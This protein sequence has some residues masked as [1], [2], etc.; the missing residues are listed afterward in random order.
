MN[1]PPAISTPAAVAAMVVT[2]SAAWTAIAAIARARN[3]ASCGSPRERLYIAAAGA[4][5]DFGVR[6]R[7]LALAAG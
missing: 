7:G 6:N 4:L 1:S 2:A 3:Q 5:G